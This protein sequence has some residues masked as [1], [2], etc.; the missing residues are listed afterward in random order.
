M[1]PTVAISFSG[2]VF[3]IR[4][5]GNAYAARD[6]LKAAGYKW[7]GA[8]WHI[9]A[10]TLGDMARA[11]CAAVDAGWTVLDA[12]HKTPLAQAKIDAARAKLA[13]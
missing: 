9:Q 8:N 11:L 3:Q 5:I 1:A 7:D 13:A 10:T 4:A 6:T 2:K 12:D